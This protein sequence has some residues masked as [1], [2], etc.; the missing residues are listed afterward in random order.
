MGR[1]VPTTSPRTTIGQIAEMVR[2][3]PYLAVPVVAEDGTLLGL[4]TEAVIARALM[5]VSD[6]TARDTIRQTPIGEYPLEIP[7]RFL[8]SAERAADAIVAMDASGR[9]VLPV[10]TFAGGPFLGL[11]SR[12]DLVQE[13]VRPF[14]PPT[15]GGM[16]TPH[17]VYLTTGTASGGVTA[18]A[19]ILTGLMMFTAQQLPLL[20]LNPIG[21]WAAHVAGGGPLA[22]AFL[23]DGLPAAGALLVFL[24]AVRFS[25]LA[26][27]HAAEHQV[28]HAIER[29]EPLLIENV[30]SMPRVHPRCGTNLVAGG[31]IFGVVTGILNP[32]ATRF[33][34]PAVAGLTYG[35]AGI[36]ALTYWRTLGSFLQFWFT[37]RPATDKQLASG[38][39]AAREVLERHERQ[40]NAKPLRPHV[41]LWRMGLLQMVIGFGIGYALLMLVELAWPASRACI[42]PLLS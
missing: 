38:I 13:L 39:R 16:A 23:G 7:S 28:V 1:W 36:V 5:S 35:L 40:G 4:A 6:T 3:S 30:R 41:R 2:A 11:I 25:P 18:L 21:V 31:L 24:C 8:T 17:G 9:E 10:L 22:S 37:T 42:G 20:A 29:S 33:L 34:P 32:I 14:R 12:G 19:L 27:Y 26:G 15:I